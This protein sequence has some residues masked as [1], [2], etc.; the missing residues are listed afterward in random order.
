MMVHRLLTYAIA[1][2]WLINGLVCKVLNGV[3]RHELIVARILGDA[4]APV[5]TRAIGVSEMLMA[6]WVVSRIRP[7]WCAIAQIGLVATMNGIEFVLAPDLLLFG[8]L[9]ALVAFLF[10]SIVYYNEFVLAPSHASPSA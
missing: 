4:Y 8:R 9:N 10:I 1:A 7:R 3:P 2:V 6:V 5:L